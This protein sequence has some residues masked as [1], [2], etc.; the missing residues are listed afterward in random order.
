PYYPPA[1]IQ[2]L[3]SFDT[4]DLTE[5]STNLYSQ[6]ETYSDSGFALIQPKDSTRG[7]HLGTL[8]DFSPY[9]L[10]ATSKAVFSSEGDAGFFFSPVS[11]DPSF[12]NAGQL[13]AGSRSRGSLDS[14]T[15]IV[16]GDGIW[17]FVGM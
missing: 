13:I 16:S 14:P 2:D 12:F 11:G 8:T 9:S 3:S 7:L 4:D 15:P 17:G 6:W 5:G 10:L 1:G